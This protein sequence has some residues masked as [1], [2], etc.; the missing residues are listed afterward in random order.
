MIDDLLFPGATLRAIVLRSVLV[1][2]A[3]TALA[4]LLGV[5]VGYMIA[6]RT[7][8][9][10]TVLLGFINT[11]MGMP[12]VV[13]A[14]WCLLLVRS[15]PRCV[16]VHL[17]QPRGALGSLRNPRSVSWNDF[18]QNLTEMLRA[19]TTHKELSEDSYRCWC[20]ATQGL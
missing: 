2:G 6:R 16:R 11:G 4:V 17:D 12:P 14:C 3:A 13:V 5:P 19:A 8:P 20:V 9:G 15:G 1:S 10:R 18:L 7:F